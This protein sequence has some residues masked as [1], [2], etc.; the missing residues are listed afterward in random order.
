MDG[1]SEARLVRIGF[2]ITAGLIFLAGFGAGLGV[3]LLF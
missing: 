2:A 1:A 3:G